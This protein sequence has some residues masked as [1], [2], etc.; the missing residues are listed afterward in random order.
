MTREQNKMSNL[1]KLS[2]R[3]LKKRAAEHGVEG[4]S[5]MDRA[6]LLEA[7][8]NVGNGSPGN[9]PGEPPPSDCPPPAEPTAPPYLDRGRPIPDTYGDD[10][11]CIMISGARRGYVYWE[12]SGSVT[13]R[14]R[15]AYGEDILRSSQWILRVCSLRCREAR[16]IPISVSS[17]RWFVDLEPGRLYLV[18]LGFYDEGGGFVSVLTSAPKAT[19]V[20]TVSSIL[21]ESWPIGWA[22]MAEKST[23]A[24]EAIQE[25]PS[26]VWQA[27]FREIAEQSVSAEEA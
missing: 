26:A 21:D 1:H 2:V 16:D 12:L 19:P 17:S 14:F 7:L 23:R 9:V 22:E 18:H 11:L 10:R 25:Y 20:E 4:R 13:E 6:Q 24:R 8:L 5:R 27:R 15:L 3:D